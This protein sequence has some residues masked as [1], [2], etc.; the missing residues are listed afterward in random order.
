MTLSIVGAQLPSFIPDCIGQELLKTLLWCLVSD[1]GHN[2]AGCPQGDVLI[3]RFHSD[4]EFPMGEWL[5]HALVWLWTRWPAGLGVGAEASFLGVV[6]GK[7]FVRELVGQ[8]FLAS[9][10]AKELFLALCWVK[11]FV[12][13]GWPVVSGIPG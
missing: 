9:Q 10:V 5:V 11:T 4:E 12:R 8:F 1:G 13:T 6:L 7:G 2:K 3:G